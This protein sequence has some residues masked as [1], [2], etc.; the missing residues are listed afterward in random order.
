MTTTTKTLNFGVAGLGVAGAGILPALARHPQVRI[1]AAAD[2][3]PE[4]R[5][6][7]VSEHGGIAYQDIEQLCADKSIDCVYLAT[8]TPMHPEHAIMALESGKHVVVE[9]PMALNLEAADRIIDA[10]DRTGRVLLVGH[11]HSYDPPI[12]KAREIV[13]SGR[14]GAVRMINNW[15]FNDWIYRPRLRD[16]LDSSLGGG[17]TF[18]QGSHQFDIIR[19]IAGGRVR[20]VRAVTG[21]WDSDRPTE[22]MH[23]AFL[24]FENGVGATAVYSGYDHFHSIELTGISEGGTEW[25]PAEPHAKARKAIRGIGSEETM[26]RAGGYGGSRNRRNSDEEPH[27]SFYGLTVITCEHGDIRQSPDGLIIY[28]DDEREEIALPRGVTG[29]DLMISELCDAVLAGKPARHD[30]RWGKANLEVCLATLESGRTHQE[31]Y[32]KHQVATPD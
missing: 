12:A 31:V 21:A 7:F 2:H 11:S 29:R 6:R 9:K 26:K 17:V 25:N 30:G 14:L 3:R 27:Q 15:Y 5:D 24:E 13:A 22:G 19:Y 10:A 32:L 20:S 4:P 23:V 18:R 28:G 8:P 1:A 16:E